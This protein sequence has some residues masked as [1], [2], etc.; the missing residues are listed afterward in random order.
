MAPDERYMVYAFGSWVR[1]PGTV[2]LL[3]KREK[4]QEISKLSGMLT[5][6][7]NLLYMLSSEKL[8]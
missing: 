7:W 3:G 2:L 4:Y 6:S 5:I 8:D 1:W